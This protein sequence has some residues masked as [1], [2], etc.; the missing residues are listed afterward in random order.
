MKTT[1]AQWVF[2]L[3]SL[4]LAGLCSIIVAGAHARFVEVEERLTI[5]ERRAIM[6]AEERGKQTAI[7][8]LIQ[9]DIM[10]IRTRLMNMEQRTYA[11]EK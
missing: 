1:I 11:Q 9:K 7:L 2:S 5:I 4:L 10:D 8:E 6:D 3:A